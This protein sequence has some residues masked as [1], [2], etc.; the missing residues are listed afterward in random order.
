MK[1]S[2]NRQ[3]DQFGIVKK[4]ILIALILAVIILWAE[5]GEARQSGKNEVNQSTE[6]IENPLPTLAAGD[7]L[8]RMTYAEMSLGDLVLVNAQYGY[9][10]GLVSVETLY[11]AA[12]DT[13]YVADYEIAVQSHIIEHLNDWMTDFYNATYNDE[14]L[15][16]AGHRTVEYQ[17]GLYM[18]A[19]ENHG[20]AHADA[21]I[22]LPG[23]SEHHTGLAI[24][25]DTYTSYGNLGGFDGEGVFARLVEDAWKYGF[26]QRYP[27]GKADITGISYEA[28]HFRYVG[29]PHSK[30]MRDNDLCLEEYIEFLKNYPYDGQHLTVEHE[31][32]SY[33][34]YYC[35]GVE[36]PVPENGS[37]TTSGNNVDGFIVTVEKET[38][39]G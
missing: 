32:I 27:E 14:A 26:V 3:P 24:D 10:D 28:W 21:Y 12:A 35:A 9:E 18:Q 33:E 36:V 37:Y 4:L 34:I 8:M 5:A 39:D 20:Q 16:V 11:P 2:K 29:L 17:Q 13:Y 31:G 30:V 25:L 15:V 23:H 22:A 6:S 1:K 19:V 38:A 7:K